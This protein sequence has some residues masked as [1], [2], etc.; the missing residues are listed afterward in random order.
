MEPPPSL[1]SHLEIRAKP[2]R[3]PERSKNPS[4]QGFSF[5]FSL[6][7][8]RL[9]LS[10]SLSPCYLPFAEG[11]S[12]A[13]EI[14]DEPIQFYVQISPCLL[15]RYGHCTN[16][17]C[18]RSGS[19]KAVS[20]R[21]ASSLFS[22]LIS[23]AKVRTVVIS[24]SFFHYHFIGVTPFLVGS[25]GNRVSWH[26]S[27]PE[28]A[29]GVPVAFVMLCGEC[30]VID[31]G[32]PGASLTGILS[33]CSPLLLPFPFQV[34]LMLVGFGQR[35]HGI[36]KTHCFGLVAGDKCYDIADHFSYAGSGCHK[37]IE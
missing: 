17:F 26:D 21:S 5:L 28:W 27:S 35:R 1:I 31:F 33:K 14:P 16:L 6:L 30:R 24:S 4:R 2:C 13:L 23:K 32:A 22:I 25:C 15:S 10:L 36:L 9:R 18:C 20:F 11:W 29:C 34:Q 3:V 19:W 7:H 37:K 8:S 12:Q